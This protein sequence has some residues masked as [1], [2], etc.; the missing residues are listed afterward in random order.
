[1]LFENTPEL[2]A[3]ELGR[4]RRKPRRAY[5]SP[6]SDAFQ[7]LP[8]V[9]D[10]SF[11]TMTVLLSADVGVSFLTKGFVTERFLDLFADRSALVFA[12]IGLATLDLSLI[13]ISEPTRPY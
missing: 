6:S 9:Q 3:K 10:V 7:Y 4:R 12:Q 8:Q 13:H 5:F 11:R 1:V 2:V